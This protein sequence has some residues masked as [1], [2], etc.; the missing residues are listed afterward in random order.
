MCKI[1]L[2]LVLL[3]LSLSACQAKQSVVTE[4]NSNSGL[5]YTLISM[6]GETRVTIRIAWPSNWAFSGERNQAARYIGPRLLLTGGAEGYK[7]IDVEERFSEMGSEGEM[8][9]TIDYLLGSVHYSRKH[10]DE[11]LKIINAHL[12]NPSLNAQWFDRIR[13]QLALEMNAAEASAESQ[14]FEA[15][16]WALFGEQPI[17]AALALDEQDVIELEQIKTGDIATWAKSVIKRNGVVITIAGDLNAAE[18]GA[19]IDSLF[20]GVPDGDVT[21]RGSVVADYS[22]KRLLL[23]APESASSNLSF[24]GK[25]PGFDEGS[26]LEDTLITQ[27]LSDYLDEVLYGDLGEEARALYSYNAVF[28][29]FTADQRFILLTGPV[30]T[31][32]IADAET[33]LLKAYKEFRSNPPISDDDL[34]QLKEPYRKR[35]KKF[36]KNTGSN[37]NSALMAKL[38]GM[39]PARALNL[40]DE[41]D[42]VT[43]QTLKRRLQTAFPSVEEFFVLVDSADATVLP[44]ACIIKTPEEALNC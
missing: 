39:D 35:F 23:H 18:A 29:A 4:Q 38:H 37:S 32:N 15:L 44:L 27:V 9:A 33:V 12:R 36:S 7:A 1:K 24:F 40:Q 5:A 19:A 34:S 30:A 11:T 13:D 42:A 17:R 2:M 6:P 10:Q 41:L 20:D 22:P 3:V 8:Q 21:E 14:V 16:R 31:E 28:S 43:M 26:E 25:L